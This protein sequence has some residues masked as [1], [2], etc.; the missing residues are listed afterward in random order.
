MNESESKDGLEEKGWQ[1]K[2]L[3]A[4]ILSILQAWARLKGGQRGKAVA[5]HEVLSYLN[6]MTTRRYHH[7]SPGSLT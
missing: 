4:A 6:S 5:D 1:S 3:L 2:T 7:I